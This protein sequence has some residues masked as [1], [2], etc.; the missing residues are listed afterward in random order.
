MTPDTLARVRSSLMGHE[1]LVLRAYDDK[2]GRVVQPGTTVGGWVTIGY[3]RNLVGRGI[4]RDEADYLLDND[5][6]AVTAD[7]D[8]I[9][10]EWRGWSEARQWA[11]FEVAFNLGAHRFVGGWPNTVA[12]MRAGRWDD[13]AAAFSGSLWRRQVGDSRALPIIRALRRGDFL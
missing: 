13:V 1:G 12:A 7:L 11:V 8:R 4:T 10:P 3:G 2:T 9:L 6:D 5:L